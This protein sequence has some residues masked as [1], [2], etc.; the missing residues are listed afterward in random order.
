M[1]KAAFKNAEETKAFVEWAREQLIGM[2]QHVH[3]SGLI[4]TEPV[5][6]CVWAIPHQLFIGQIWPKADRSAAYWVISGQQ[7]PTDHIERRLAETARDAA[8]HFSLKWQLHSAKLSYLSEEEGDSEAGA[9]DS[10]ALAEMPA[11][12]PESGGEGVAWS[13]VADTLQ[14]PAETLYALVEQDEVWDPKR[15]D[16]RKHLPPDM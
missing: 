16:I 13:E 2:G 6:R 1:T 10:P 3:T 7:V 4:T 12:G 14:R 11:G 8:R 5:G 15:I 9:T